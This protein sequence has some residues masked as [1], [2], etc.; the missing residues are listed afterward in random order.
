MPGVEREGVKVLWME[1]RRV[2]LRTCTSVPGLSWL[3]RLCGVGTFP[4][5]A[6]TARGALQVPGGGSCS[7]LSLFPQ[8]EKCEDGL[9]LSTGELAVR[10]KLVLPAGP[11]KPQEAQEGT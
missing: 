11:S 8:A 2:L 6:R 1:S 3:G 10:A 5:R 7:E 9:A 4:G